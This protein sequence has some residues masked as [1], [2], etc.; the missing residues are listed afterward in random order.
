MVKSIK[1]LDKSSLSDQELKRL[2]ARENLW[3][4]V[5]GAQIALEAVEEMLVK[6]VIEEGRLAEE[7]RQRCVCEKKA[8]YVKT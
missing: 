6:D 7:G 2:F 5:K 3:I 8:M 4:A 1:S